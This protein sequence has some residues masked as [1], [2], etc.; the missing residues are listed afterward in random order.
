[1]PKPPVPPEL[2]EFLAQ[3]NPSVIATL[4]PDG[5]PHTAA[6]WYIWEGGRV[7]VNMD[8]GRKRLDYLRKDPRVSL[9]VLGKDDWYHHVT[10]RGRV[11]SLEEDDLTDIDR[12]SR[13]YT[14]QPYSDRERG[15]V[16]AWIEVE[17]YHSW[18]VNEP[19]RGSEDAGARGGS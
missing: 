5:S 17:T 12:L 14:G 9:T 10:L 11:V 19:W 6:T 1:M 2:D 16:S 3:P 7:L 4:Q 18:A 8:Q 15:R 13:H